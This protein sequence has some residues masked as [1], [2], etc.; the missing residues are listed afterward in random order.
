VRTALS[1]AHSPMVSEVC[2][3]GVQDVC[4]MRHST[5]SW[6]PAVPFL[7]P[8]PAAETCI[9]TSVHVYAHHRAVFT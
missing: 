6:W 1:A 9:R 2:N 5:D 7:A 4:F 3:I 8:H